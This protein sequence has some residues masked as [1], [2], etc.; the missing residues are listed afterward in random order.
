[1]PLVFM[2]F[3]MKYY[4]PQLNAVKLGF[5]AVRYS[6]ILFRAISLTYYCRLG[7]LLCFVFMS[8]YCIFD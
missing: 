5:S 7:D 2:L 6:D 4:K 8:A 1:M 3:Q